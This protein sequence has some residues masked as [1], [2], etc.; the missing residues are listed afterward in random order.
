VTQDVKNDEADDVGTTE[1]ELDRRG[2]FLRQL[3]RPE[4]VEEEEDGNGGAVEL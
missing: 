2:Y 4:E 3:K 1:L